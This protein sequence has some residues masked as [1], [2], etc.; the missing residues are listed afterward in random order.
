[1]LSASYNLV[2]KE[3]GSVKNRIYIIIY[4]NTIQLDLP[5]KI[6]TTLILKIRD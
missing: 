4:T 5:S 1:M 3:N 6:G 2:L